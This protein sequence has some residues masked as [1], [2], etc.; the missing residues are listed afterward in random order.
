MTVIA[1]HIN[2]RALTS[3]HRHCAVHQCGD[4]TD[5]PPTAQVCVVAVIW[6]KGD[7]FVSKP[8]VKMNKQQGQD[9]P[10]LVLILA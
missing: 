5:R 9:T 6:R 7:T 4:C 8:S 2:F 1:L 3:K 10:L